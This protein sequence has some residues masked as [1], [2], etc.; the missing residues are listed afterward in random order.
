MDANVGLVATPQFNLMSAVEIYNVELFLSV[1]LVS[2]LG[3][4]GCFNYY[5]VLL[6]L[7]DLEN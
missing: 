3:Y 7:F 2:W 6:R 1:I 5:E 4:M